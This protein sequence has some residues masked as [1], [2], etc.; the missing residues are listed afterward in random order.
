MFRSNA[1][2]IGCTYKVLLCPDKSELA[3]E[4]TDSEEAI[5]RVYQE[6]A[7]G[8]WRRSSKTCFVR[9]RFGSVKWVSYV[10]G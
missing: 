10:D 2:R 5:F 9:G 6:T 8:G 7:I 4:K 1:A 3:I